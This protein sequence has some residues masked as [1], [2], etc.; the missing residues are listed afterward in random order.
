[1]KGV[2]PLLLLLAWAH[3]SPVVAYS[4][5]DLESALQH[6]EDLRAG[7]RLSETDMYLIGYAKGFVRAT[8]EALG[9]NVLCLPADATAAQAEAIVLKYLKANP[10]LWQKNAVDLVAAALMV[11][12]TCT[13]Q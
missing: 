4:G 13:K 2:P 11:T 1:M 10:E 5:A 3:A 7:V 6:E 12:F 9:A 8:S